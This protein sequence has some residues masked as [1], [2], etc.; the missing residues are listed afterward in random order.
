[1]VPDLLHLFL[2]ISGRL[3]SKLVW[4]LRQKDNIQRTISSIDPTVDTNLI[5]FENRVKSFGVTFKV[6]IDDSGKLCITDLPV[7][8]R[9][10]VM[11]G[12]ILAEFGADNNKIEDIQELSLRISFLFTINFTLVSLEMMHSNSM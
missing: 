6:F 10:K 8:Q 5:H 4:D 11:R 1:M 7:R 3:L 9:L 2:R 12:L